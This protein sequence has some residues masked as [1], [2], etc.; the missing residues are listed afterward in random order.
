MAGGII[1]LATIAAPAIGGRATASSVG[2]W[3]RT[4][5]LPSWTPPSWVFGPVWTAL[6]VMM[7]VAAFLVWWRLG[8]RAET[9]WSPSMRLPAG[10]YSV[11][12]VLN[13]L[14]SVLFFGMRSPGLAAV[15]IWVL[16]VAIVLTM[17]VFARVWL[18]AGL[19]LV[20][21]LVW[22]SFAGVL[23]VAI[24]WLNR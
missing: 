14:W 15:E 21:Y 5:E 17:V 18:W 24:W 13:A 3:Y 1:G 16:W 19:L 4:L 6:Y 12:L 8:R 2:T 10:L 23:N 22:T 7:G 20:P 9:A 11:Q